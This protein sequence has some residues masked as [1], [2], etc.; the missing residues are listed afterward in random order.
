V[1]VCRESGVLVADANDLDLVVLDFE[2]RRT[3]VAAP[4][5]ELLAEALEARRAL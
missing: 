1:L 3:L 4:T 5:P 2:A